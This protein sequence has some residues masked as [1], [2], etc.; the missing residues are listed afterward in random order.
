MASP[1]EIHKNVNVDVL[2]ETG[3]VEALLEALQ[4]RVK[5]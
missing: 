5:R 3:A 2:L 1:L 4:G